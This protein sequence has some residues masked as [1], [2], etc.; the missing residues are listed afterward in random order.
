M[1]TVYDEPI[2]SLLKIHNMQ[3]LE[4]QIWPFINTAFKIIKELRIFALT[5]S[6]NL[7]QTKDEKKNPSF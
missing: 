6:C 5:S 4:V 7:M 1:L 2:D 3:D